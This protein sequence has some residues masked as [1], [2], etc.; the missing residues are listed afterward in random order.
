FTSR[1]VLI[2]RTQT[3]ISYKQH[4]SKKIQTIEP[5][6]RINFFWPERDIKNPMLCIKLTDSDYEW[7]APFRV[8]VIG[9]TFTKLLHKDQKNAPYILNVN[10]K[11]QYA[12]LF[13]IIEKYEQPPYKIDNRTD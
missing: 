11:E 1:Y 5:N 9:T 3:K 6:K 13:I 2:N 12:T 10:V 4:L 7:S 8:D